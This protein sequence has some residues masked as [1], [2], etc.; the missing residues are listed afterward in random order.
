MKK[1]KIYEPSMCC[2]TGLCGVGIDKELLRLST[3]LSNLKKANINVERFNLTDSPMEFVDN[4]KISKLLEENGVEILPVTIVDNTVIK[5]GG[6]PS[7]EEIV[8][9]LDVSLSLIQ[10][11]KEEAGKIEEP[12]AEG[13]CGPAGGCC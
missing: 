2:P 1:M 12:E 11:D 4:E 9:F 5:T 7:N 8:R 13:C 10:G 3:V 6:Y